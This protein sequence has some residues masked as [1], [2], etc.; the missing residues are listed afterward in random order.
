[1]Q[2]LPKINLNEVKAELCRRSLSFFVKEFWEVIIQDPIVWNWHMD[3]LCDEVQKVYEAV[4][5]RK[6]KLY[7]LIINIPPGTSKS[8]IATVM[9]PVWSW[10]RDSSLRHITG[11]YS[12]SLSTEHAVKSRDIIRSDKFRLYFP[13]IEIKKDEDNKT[14][15]KTTRGGQR[16]ATSVTGTITGTHAHII[17]I[18]DPLNPKQAA[19]D[20]ELST[21]NDFFSSTLPTRK[22]DKEVTPI[23][24]IMQRLAINDPTGYLLSK[25]KDNVRKVCLPATLNNDVQPEEYKSRYIN[26][27]LDPVRLGENVLK[28]MKI[29]LGSS[30]YAGQMDQNPVPPGGLIL[31]EDWFEIVDR[32]I[33]KDAVIHF[34]LDTAY[35]KNQENDPTAI[36]AYYKDNNDIYITHSESNW[37]EFPDLIKWVVPFVKN[38]GYSDRSMVRIE[39]KAS[40]KSTVQQLKQDT[41]LNVKESENPEKDKI[42]RCNNASP[43]IE[44]GRVKLHRG[45]WNKAFIDQCCSFPKGEHDD[46][47]DNLT[48]I[49]RNELLQP[50]KFVGVIK[51][52]A[53]MEMK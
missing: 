23:I 29:D 11:S 44:A 19:S 50:R 25:G 28:E 49:I 52:R 45:G 18:D 30:G 46:E 42:T 14:N 8:T 7:D 10:I 20:A 34:Q 51:T 22:V 47:L 3:A 36:T 2:N 48:E 15:Y 13:G 35:T 39:P 31:K 53:E 4:I 43:K 21:A 1:M 38:H 40:G 9:A 16:F 32:P 24:L 6:P 41:S 17:T 12:D 37:F 26:G 5:S 27:Y 33:P